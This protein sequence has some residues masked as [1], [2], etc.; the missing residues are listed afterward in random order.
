MGVLRSPHPHFA[1][2]FPTTFQ[3]STLSSWPESVLSQN[4]GAQ[5]DYNNWG[6]RFRLDYRISP[7]SVVRAGFGMSTLAWNIDLFA[8]NYPLEPT[9][10]Y[11][12]LSGLGPAI[13]PSDATASFEQDPR[14]CRL[15]FSRRTGSSRPI[16][17]LCSP[18]LL[19]H[20]LELEKPVSRI[21][22]FCL[23]ANSAWKLGV[24]CCLRSESWHPYSY[25][26]Q[27]DAATVYGTGAAGQPEYG[28]CAACGSPNANVGRTAAT[29]ELFCGL[30]LELQCPSGQ[31]R[32]QVRSWLLR[33]Q[34]VHVR[35]GPWV[36]QRSQ[37]LPQWA[38]GLRQPA[39]QLCSDGLQPNPHL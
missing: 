27:P 36:C 33:H 18:E 1:G 20:Q 19:C 31:V 12:S 3:A 13:L 32:S 17:L 25:P 21:M 30:Q 37:R 9:Q 34:L 8:Y 15:M 38:P 16:H 10:S 23:R 39:A 7:N 24:R 5:P 2:V 28:P 6:P 4:I 11:N 26:I 14:H 35:K 29:T 22:E